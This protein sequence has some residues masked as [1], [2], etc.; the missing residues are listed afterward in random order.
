V[1]VTQ[2]SRLLD[3][4]TLPVVPYSK[5]HNVS[6]IWSVTVLRWGGGKHSG[7]VQPVSVGRMGKMLL[8]LVSPVTFDFGCRRDPWPNFCSFQDFYMLWKGASSSRRGGFWLL[9]GTS[10]LL[11]ATRAD[12]Q[13][14][15]G[16][17]LHKHS[18]RDHLSGFHTKIQ[19]SVFGLLHAHLTAL[20]NES[21]VSQPVSSPVHCCWPSPAQSF[22]VSAPGGT[23][24]Q[25][26]VRS[27]TVYIQWLGLATYVSI[28]TFTY[29]LELRVCQRE[30][31][32]KCAI[33]IVI[34]HV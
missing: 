13:S 8:A 4:W 28:T 23:R 6:E 32:G 3:V 10:P 27:K 2:N 19:T 17:F 7:V 34:M 1:Q 12:S 9:L 26:F 31:T 29:V 15:T 5:E 30:V 22:S 11:G 14:L 16:P 25:I 24:D 33:K 21:S 18:I 20:T